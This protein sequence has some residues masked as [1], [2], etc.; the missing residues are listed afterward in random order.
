[1]RVK[2]V[3][4]RMGRKGEMHEETYD[5]CGHTRYVEH[6]LGCIRSRSYG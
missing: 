6:G 5:F 3:T 1:M 2:Q 4:L